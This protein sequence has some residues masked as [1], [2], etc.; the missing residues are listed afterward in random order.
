MMH[1]KFILCALVAI[2]STRS[3][4]V[5]SIPHEKRGFS[6]DGTYYNPGLGA[7][8][9]SSGSGSF[10]AAINRPQ[11][12]NPANPNSNPICGKQAKVTG[13][14]GSCTVTI[15][16]L[17]PECAFGS[18]D[19]SPAAFNAIADPNAGRVPISWDFV[20]VFFFNGLVG[21]KS[22]PGPSTLPDGTNPLDSSSKFLKGQPHANDN[23]SIDDSVDDIADN[24]D[25]EK[26]KTVSSVSFVEATPTP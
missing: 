19:L 21:T 18:L 12:G 16:D 25:S 23:N 13:P 22:G 17:C 1:S 14:K 15:V 8:G 3:Y 9:Q 6:G 20:A 4:F 26:G 5:S 2:L 10:I 7:C 24:S 11:W